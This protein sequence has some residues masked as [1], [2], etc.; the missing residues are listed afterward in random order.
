M[1]APT[2]WKMIVIIARL[3]VAVVHGQRDALAL[4]V[5]AQ[6]D[7][8][9]RLDLLRD[10]GRAHH[11]A[12]HL[13][14]SLPL[15]FDGMHPALLVSDT[16]LCKAGARLRR[17]GRQYSPKRCRTIYYRHVSTRPV[18]IA[19]EGFLNVLACVSNPNG[20]TGEH[21]GGSCIVS[22]ESSGPRARRGVSF[23]RTRWLT[24]TFCT[25]ACKPPGRHA[26]IDAD[27]PVVEV[28][29][30]LEIGGPASSSSETRGRCAPPRSRAPASM[31]SPT[32]S[33]DRSPC[34]ARTTSCSTRSLSVLLRRHASECSS[35]TWHHLRARSRGNRL[36][37]R[38]EAAHRRSLPVRVRED[39]HEERP[40]LPWPIWDRMEERGEVHHRSRQERS[41]RTMLTFRRSCCA[42]TRTTSSWWTWPAA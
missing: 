40:L 26:P 23:G 25:T 12:R 15:L 13:R 39:A 34:P 1:V 37:R 31:C 28:L 33:S 2:A 42:S 32:A 35:T 6:H 3:R 30:S 29:N 8:L 41:S 24:S 10:L 19:P 22:W 9:T 11:H 38:F 7:E 20:A 4:L 18:E 21:A 14:M 36:A 27:Q 16:S 5:D 17:C